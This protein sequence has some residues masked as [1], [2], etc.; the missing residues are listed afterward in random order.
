MAANVSVA[1]NDD[2]WQNDMIFKD[3]DDCSKIL[4]CELNS[5]RRDGKSLTY[6]ETIKT[7]SSGQHDASKCYKV[8]LQQ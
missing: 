8:P 5:M 2:I 7:C 4:V 3:Q 6:T 1:I